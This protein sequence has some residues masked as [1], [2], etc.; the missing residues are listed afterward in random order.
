MFG[1]KPVAEQE[2]RMTSV[3][4]DVMK[5]PRMKDCSVPQYSGSLHG[6]SDC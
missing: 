4:M 6:Q 3:G 2:T 5:E 1:F